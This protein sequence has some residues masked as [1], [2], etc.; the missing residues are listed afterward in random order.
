MAKLAING[1]PKTIDRALGK[2]WPIRGEEEEQAVVE[3][4][5]SGAWW[6]GSAEATQV[7]AFEDE[8]AAYQNA[9]HCVAV[10]NGTTAIECALKSVGVEAGDEVL[11]PALTFV[12]SATAIP[13]VNGIPVFV[14]VDPGTFNI[15]PDAME[16]A[17]TPRT[18]AAVVVHNGGYP[19]DM[20]R[21]ADIA[22]KH[23]I[24]IVEDSAHAHGSEWKGTRIGALV[25]M[26]TFSF[27]MGKTLTCGEG[28]AVVTNDDELAEKAFSFHHIGR[29]K[30]RPFYEFHRVASNLRMTEWQGA[31]LRQ[32]LKR[33]DD[34]IA[35][36]TRNY[37]RLIE[38]FKDIDG[39]DPIALDERVT[40]WSFYYWNFRYNPEAFGGVPRDTFLKAAAAEGVPVGVG[41]H[42]GVIYKN[43][44][45]QSMNFGRTGCPVKCPLHQGEKVDFTKVCCP[46]AERVA[47][48]VALSI[49]HRIFLG[50]VEDM[51]LIL[52]GIK[53][54]RDNVDELKA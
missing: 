28:G 26:G 4:V 46:Q 14:D 50:G 7:P 40:R 8:W 3:V 34:Q 16:A 20:D 23:G 6:R 52:E 18:R 41:A 31:I 48:D 9:K 39:I 10:T 5:R 54:I 53:K 38:G 25:D 21:I 49:T 17:I 11:V 32:Q 37:E 45:F 13:L 24:A 30:D 22:A 42:G 19:C 29:V 15:D 47:N 12:A 33:L 36:R 27:Q 51:D 44:L 43:P 1:G 2:P 35:T